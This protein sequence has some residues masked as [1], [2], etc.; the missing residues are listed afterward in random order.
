MKK[1]SI[2]VALAATAAFLAG[3]SSAAFAQNAQEE[4][5][6]QI[7]KL[8]GDA[9]SN[10]VSAKAL[11]A[12]GQGPASAEKNALWGSYT[13][14]N[15]DFS[16]F[17]FTGDSR[18]NMYV[19]GYDRDVTANFIAGVAVNYVDSSFSGAGFSADA[20]SKGLSPYLTYLFTKN[21]FGMLRLDY[22]ESSGGGATIESYGA[23]ASINGVYRSGD[24]VGRGRLEVGTTKSNSAALGGTQ[25]TTIFAG[26]GELGYYLTPTLYG[27]VGLQLSESDSP[28]SYQASARIGIESNINR[29]TAV[30]LKY[31]KKIDDN[32]P[33]GINIKINS[34]TL[35][36]RLRF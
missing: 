19:A 7:A 4:V 3:A 14:L 24:L 32:L 30:S 2:F 33:S 21:I 26:D 36:L 22:N 5:N 34:F 28:N 11:D 16:A 15:V 27:H 9:I 6:K 13:R 10:R 8:I 25:S 35:A 17:G 1:N 29:T 31:E 23:A 12:A 18:S 20:H